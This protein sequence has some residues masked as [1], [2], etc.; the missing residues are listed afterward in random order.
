MRF[1][2]YRT[3]RVGAVRADGGWL[4]MKRKVR[5]TVKELFED[6]SLFDAS[7]EHFAGCSRDVLKVG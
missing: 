7:L 4:D 2:Y 6:R 1:P 5:P 3:A